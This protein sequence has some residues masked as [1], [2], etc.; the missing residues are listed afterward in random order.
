V[1]K[2]TKRL[3]AALRRATKASDAFDQLRK[4]LDQ[5][6]S[7]LIPKDMVD[8]LSTPQLTLESRF[9]ALQ[10]QGASLHK[11]LKAGEA[12]MPDLARSLH[13]DLVDLSSDLEGSFTRIHDGLLAAVSDELRDEIRGRL[14]AEQAWALVEE[15]KTQA[16]RS[17]LQLGEAGKQSSN[18]ELQKRARRLG[19]R[20]ATFPQREESQ[21]QADAEE[22]LKELKT[23]ALEAQAAM[24]KVGTSTSSHAQLS[25]GSLGGGAHEC[26]TSFVQAIGTQLQHLA[27]SFTGSL[28]RVMLPP[29]VANLQ[30]G[31]HSMQVMRSL[32][33][34]DLAMLDKGTPLENTSQVCM[35]YAGSVRQL[36]ADLQHYRSLLDH[37]PSEGQ[38]MTKAR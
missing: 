4:C 35:Q 15:A 36:E 6:S 18:S 14:A 23:L 29:E 24:P 25:P 10:A 28:Q 3:S 20:L 21:G 9:V 5:I 16:D 22:L 33:L 8:M 38:A 11:R 26:T 1:T 27:Q 13:D 31:L 7:E 19:Y 37:R 32:L 2:E 12:V 34:G 17:I 30:R